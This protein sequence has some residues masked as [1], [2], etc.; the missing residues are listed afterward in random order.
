MKYT[1]KA[2]ET[3]YR[4]YMFRSRLEA[5][6]AAMFDLLNWRWEYE[7][8]DFNGWIP[9]FAIYGKDVVYVEVKPVFEFPSDVAKKLEESGCDK[10][11]LIVGQTIDMADELHFGWLCEHADELQGWWWSEAVAARW[12]IENK[13]EWRTGFCHL[14]G[15]WIDRISG[16]Y[17]GS[18]YAPDE[19][20]EEFPKLWA[21]AHKMTRWNKA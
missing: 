3:N 12:F 10:E 2:I 16:E 8:T 6:W 17:H 21:K 20:Q 19:L 11:M 9:D 15:S 4:G 14:D 13:G 5:R 1:M 18:I 7:P